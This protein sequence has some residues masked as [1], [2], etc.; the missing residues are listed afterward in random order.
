MKPFVW[1]QQTKTTA[2]RARQGA[3]RI[4][5]YPAPSTWQVLA[6]YLKRSQKA[7]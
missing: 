4:L 5:V 1:K 2:L 7:E 6:K 3:T